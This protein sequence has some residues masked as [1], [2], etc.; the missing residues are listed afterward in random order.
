MTPVMGSFRNKMSKKPV[1]LL[2]FLALTLTAL[3]A[4]SPSANAQATRLQITGQVQI[5]LNL[6]L[7]DL[8]AMPQTT[9]NATLYCV[10]APTTPLEQGSWTGVQLAYLLQQANVSS[11]AMK[12]EFVASD[13]YTTDL[14]VQTATQDSTILVAYQHNGASLGGLR[15]VVPSCWGYKWIND[16]TQITLV[17]H[18]FLGKWESL[19]YPDS[20]KIGEYPTS[21]SQ[22]RNQPPWDWPGDSDASAT[23]QPSA[24]ATPTPTPTITQP[25]PTPS[26][27]TTNATEPPVVSN[28]QTDTQPPMLFY[29]TAIF[30]II[31]ISILVPLI[32][33]NNRKTNEPRKD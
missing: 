20:G 16:L 27:P 13:G 26:S 18:D 5:T 11:S 6:T 25:T 29:G 19:G 15:L 33:L 2:P 23:Q 8:K 24:T 1:I 9:E 10:D 7:D 12:V 17:N 30:V 4:V 14:T 28:L 3:L 31:A 22:N 21:T 32:A